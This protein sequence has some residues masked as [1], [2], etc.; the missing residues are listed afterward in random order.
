MQTLDIRYIFI[1]GSLVPFSLKLPR[2]YEI[3]VT[4]RSGMST[5]LVEI[6]AFAVE[7]W[8]REVALARETKGNTQPRAVIVQ[9][10][11][12]MG[13]VGSSQSDEVGASARGQQA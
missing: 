11:N 5:P 10:C 2:R 13:T 7:C 9:L 8:L 1:F 3:G 12:E 4:R 6:K